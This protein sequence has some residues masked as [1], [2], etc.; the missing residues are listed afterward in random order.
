MQANQLF[1]PDVSF[2]RIRPKPKIKPALQVLLPR[3]R[4]EAGFSC[5]H[6]RQYIS[7]DPELSGVQ[8]RNHCPHCLWSLHMD[9]NRPGDRL[10]R[11]QKRMKPVGLALKKTHR[12]YG[13]E[14]GSELMLVHVCQ[15]CGKISINRIAADD[16]AFAIWQ[17]FERSPTLAE[18]LS[19]RISQEGI[20]I[21]QSGDEGIVR[22]R[23][24]GKSEYWQ[25]IQHEA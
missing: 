2:E 8:N 10:S 12:K 7:C 25:L 9:L 24:F 18:E 21:L 16:N 3:S 20:E 4:R 22:T 13:F 1:Y 6:C 23:L 17:V 5:A 19:A 11:C 14:P 15:A